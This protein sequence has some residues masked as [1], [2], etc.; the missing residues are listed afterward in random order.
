M[1]NTAIHGLIQNDM[2]TSDSNRAH[3]DVDGLKILIYSKINFNLLEL[4]LFY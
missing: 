1:V 4:N 3:D 2:S